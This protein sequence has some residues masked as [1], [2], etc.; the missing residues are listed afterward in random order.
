M[1]KKIHQKQDYSSKEGKNELRPMRRVKCLRHKAE[2]LGLCLCYRLSFSHSGFLLSAP[3]DKPNSLPACLS[4]PRVQWSTEPLHL[5][6]MQN[7]SASADG[8]AVM[9]EIPVRVSRFAP[10]TVTQQLGE[11]RGAGGFR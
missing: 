9:S 3:A 10:A 5:I 1:G 7:S 4:V 6:L 11:R 2:G 8:T